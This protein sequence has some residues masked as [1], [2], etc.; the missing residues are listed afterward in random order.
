MF[1]LLFPCLRAVIRAVQR[2]QGKCWITDFFVSQ[3][4]KRKAPIFCSS[5]FTSSLSLSFPVTVRARRI[6]PYYLAGLSKRPRT[7][8][9]PR[10]PFFRNAVSRSTRPL[11]PPRAHAQRA[12]RPRA[13]RAALPARSSLRCT[14]YLARPADHILD[15]QGINSKFDPQTQ[16]RDM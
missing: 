8:D 16:E 2:E 1:S 4:K 10:N 3:E 9:T 7:T 11:A 6:D 12:P 5:P 13:H 14:F 15:S